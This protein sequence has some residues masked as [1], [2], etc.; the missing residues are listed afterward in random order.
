MD[1][2]KAKVLYISREGKNVQLIN[3]ALFL[4]FYFLMVVV[5]YQFINRE[6]K[7]RTWKSY[8]I[9]VLLFLYPYIIYPFQTSIYSILRFVFLSFISIFYYN[10]E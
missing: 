7:N 5:V 9:L 1:K 10:D 8:I 6:S 4:F 3:T 2:Y